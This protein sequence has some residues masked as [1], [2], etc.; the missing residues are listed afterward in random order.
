[1]TFYLFARRT[2]LFFMR[3]GYKINIEYKD[4][5]PS[6]RGF[7]LAAN[8]Q[9][10]LDPLFIGLGFK[11]KVCFMAKEEL[12]RNPILRF[13]LNNVGSFPVSRGTGDH[14]A[15]D[16]AI[17]I[18]QEGGVLGIFPEGTRSKDGVLKRAKSGA[19]LVASKTGGDI[20]PVAIKYGEKNFI[21]RNV[22]ITYGNPIPNEKL[23]IDGNDRHQLKAASIVLMS[24]IKAL[25]G[26][27]PL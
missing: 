7:I 1:M 22:L 6:D 14:S 12:F 25:L 13:I 20:V 19:V 26:D 15:I 2:V 9:S 11:R 24:E 10:N 18:V 4:N 21:R 17:A 23:M 16:R 8:H 5:L 3:F 27:Y